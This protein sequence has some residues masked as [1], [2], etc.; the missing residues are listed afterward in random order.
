MCLLVNICG[1]DKFLFLLNSENNLHWSQNSRARAARYLNPRTVY[2]LSLSL[3]P[4]PCPSVLDIF[5]A[6][7]I[8][9]SV[10]FRCY[11]TRNLPTVITTIVTRLRFKTMPVKGW[12]VNR[13]FRHKGEM[14]WHVAY[15][16]ET[17]NVCTIL[18]RKSEEKRSLRRPKH[19]WKRR[20]PFFE[21]QNVY[22]L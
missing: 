12:E 6:A 19:K 10:E 2:S 7:Q 20:N 21:N 14:C 3:S 4:S 18:N 16:R 11:F 9:Y 17:R 13:V 22:A 15:R 5:S 8:L 1:V